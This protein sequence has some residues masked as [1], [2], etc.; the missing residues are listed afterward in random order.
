MRILAV[1]YGE[2][3]TGIAVSDNSEFLASPVCTLKEWNEDRLVQR[4]ADIAKEQ[5]AGEIVVGLPLNMDGSKGEKAQKCQALGEKI[6]EVSKIPVKLWD[7]R[8]TTV[9]A[10][11]ILNT[12]NVRG[13]NRKAVVDTVAATVILESYLK[14]R[15]NSTN[16]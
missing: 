12:V 15:K 7:E 13:K 2:A 9:M 5:N 3:R 10:H 6:A 14:Y 16:K 11:Q 1:D 8:S 4:I